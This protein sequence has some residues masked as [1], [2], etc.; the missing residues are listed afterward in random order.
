MC[1]VTGSKD[2]RLPMANSYLIINVIGWG[3]GSSWGTTP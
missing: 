2:C 3:G 1:S